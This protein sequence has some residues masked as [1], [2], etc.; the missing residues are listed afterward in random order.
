MF[1]TQRLEYIDQLKGLAMLL[2]V[3]GHIIVFCGLGYDNI[4]I[5]NITMMNMCMLGELI[6]MKNLLFSF[7]FSTKRWQMNN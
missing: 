5:R 6:L 1:M 4:F 7:L 3:I 2:V